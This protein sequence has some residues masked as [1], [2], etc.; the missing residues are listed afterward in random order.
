[1]ILQNLNSKGRNIVYSKN[2][3]KHWYWFSHI[4]FSTSLR[5]LT[6]NKKS[7]IVWWWLKLRVEQWIWKDYFRY[8]SHDPLF[9]NAFSQRRRPKVQTSSYFFKQKF[10]EWCTYWCTYQNDIN[11]IESIVILWIMLKLISP[12][13]IHFNL[14]I[15]VNLVAMQVEDIAA[16]YGRK[17]SSVR[18]SN[19]IRN[20]RRCGGTPPT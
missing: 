3:S 18:P 19:D 14:F 7:L 17:S 2:N 4:T 12:N 9:T 8:G 10:S 1:M 13:N 15:K 16:F 20:D 11:G 5:S 6:L